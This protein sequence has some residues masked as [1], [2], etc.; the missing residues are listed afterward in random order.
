MLSGTIQFTDIGAL[1]DAV[2]G[3]APNDVTAVRRGDGDDSRADRLSE[4]DDDDGDEFDDGGT[5]SPSTSVGRGARRAIPRRP[6][7]ASGYGVR[8]AHRSDGAMLL[9]VPNSVGEHH[10]YHHASTGSD[11]GAPSGTSASPAMTSP[12]TSPTVAPG[13]RH[14]ATDS[15]GASFGSQGSGDSGG[16]RLPSRLPMSPNFARSRRIAASRHIAV[17]SDFDLQD[18]D[19][20]DG[21]D[22][23]DNNWMVAANR[24]WEL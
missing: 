2:R 24:H 1:G 5:L 21:D 14:R 15:S 23:L 8:P 9:S 13:H 16:G 3:L 22:E 19:N 6:G 4:R 7:A 12:M 20:V 17:P 10:H 18:L 11:S